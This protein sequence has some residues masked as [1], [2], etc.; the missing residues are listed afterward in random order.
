MAADETRGGQADELNLSNFMQN[1]G[2]LFLCSGH[3][4]RV[5]LG[6]Y[7]ETL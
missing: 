2:F 4:C 7:F 1:S 3:L 5:A 6:N